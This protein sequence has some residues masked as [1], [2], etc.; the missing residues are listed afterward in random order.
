MVDDANRRIG[1]EVNGVLVQGFVW[2]EQLRVALSL[3]RNRVRGKRQRSTMRTY[4][5][6][7]ISTRE[8]IDLRGIVLSLFG[9]EP[10]TFVDNQGEDR[11]ESLARLRKGLPKLA[12]IEPPRYVWTLTS[13]GH[14]D[15]DDFSAHAHW[16]LAKV[17]G[18]GHQ[19]HEL[20]Q[21]SCDVYMTCFWE[22]TGRGGG[23]TI[24]PDIAKLFVDAGIEL[25]FDNYF[26]DD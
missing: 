15:S 20:E 14:V 9:V 19:L 16:L 5:T 22:D 12:S 10:S 3:P 6:L 25:R 21:L 13:Q 4:C 17:G 8:E 7:V 18:S 24:S 23:A 1:N 26:V 2:Q 11:Q